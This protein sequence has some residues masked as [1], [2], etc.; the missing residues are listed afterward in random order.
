MPYETTSYNHHDLMISPASH[1]DPNSLP[2]Y[3]PSS[4]PGIPAGNHHHHHHLRSRR[5]LST[6]HRTGFLDDL[7]HVEGHEPASVVGQPGMPEPAAMPKGPKL[8]FT[9]EDD[10]LLVQLKETNDLAWKQIAH[11]FPGRSSGTLQVR[12]C[13]KLKAKAIVWNEDMVSPCSFP[14]LTPTS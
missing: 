2:T 4:S 1:H 12:Y 6:C 8:K 3:P 9:R 7:V 5:P 14:E 11:F 13:T 10:A